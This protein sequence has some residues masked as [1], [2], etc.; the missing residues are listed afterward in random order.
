M[1]KTGPNMPDPS[2]AIFEK[3][4]PQRHRV[5]FETPGVALRAKDR[6][7]GMAVLLQ[8]KKTV[9]LWIAIEQQRVFDRQYIGGSW[10]GD[11]KPHD[12]IGAVA[13]VIDQMVGYG[14]CSACAVCGNRQPSQSVR[15]DFLVIRF[16]LSPSNLAIAV[17]VE[18]NGVI[19]IAQRDVPLP[20]QMIAFD[21]KRK[22]A[23]AWFVSMG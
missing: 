17:S 5:A 8:P 7:V 6:G 2:L 16:D 23:V 21:G 15:S 18:A 13:V 22:I 3:L 12:L 9:V 19:E 20:D 4:V 14:R 1:I 11:G 10:A